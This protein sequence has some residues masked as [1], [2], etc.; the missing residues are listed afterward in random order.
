MRKTFVKGM[1]CACALLP[2]TLTAQNAAE[3]KTTSYDGPAI[4]MKPHTLD[5]LCLGKLK[6]QEKQ[7]YQGMD[8]WNDYI[9]SFQNTGYLSVYTTDGKTLKQVVKPFQIASHHEKNHCNEVTFGRIR[10]EKDDPFPLIYVAQCQRGSING[11][12]DVLYVERIA[13]DMKSTTLVQTIVFK[14][15]NKLFGYALN[16]AVD[17]ERNYLY[18]YGNTVDNTNPTN[19]HR[20]VKFRIPELSESTD[21]IVTLT[22]KD[23]LENYLIE[24]TYQAPFNP[25]GQGLM[26]RDGLLYMPTGF[27]NEKYPSELYVWDLHTRTMRNV[28]DLSQVTKGELEDCSQW[29]DKMLIQT[30]G[31]MYLLDFK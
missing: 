17:A 4:V 19:R 22:E 5:A 8:V 21:G 2:S 18:G 30:Q 23:L 31:E 29:R 12:K 27:G 20:I 13:P 25:I 28:I 11:R 15:R 1:L 14:D 6:G 16:W 7:S 26:I 3:V 10:Y 24:D 9:F